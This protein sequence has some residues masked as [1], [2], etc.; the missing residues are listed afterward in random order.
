MNAPRDPLGA[1][2]ENVGPS[3]VPTDRLLNAHQRRRAVAEHRHWVAVNAW[4]AHLGRCTSCLSQGQWYCT[5]GSY[6]ARNAIA[7][8][9]RLAEV[10]RSFARLTLRRGARRSERPQRQPAP[11]DGDPWPANPAPTPG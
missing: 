4:E 2:S 5:E 3:S 8:R 11:E 7:R 9:E 10:D 1:A 6:L